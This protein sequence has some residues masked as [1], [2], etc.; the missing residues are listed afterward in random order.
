MSTLSLMDLPEHLLPLPCF[1]TLLEY[2]GDTSL[3][4][5]IVVDDICFRLSLY[6]PSFYFI[7]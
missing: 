3:V 7:F 5:L 2:S 6:A 1:N 4:H